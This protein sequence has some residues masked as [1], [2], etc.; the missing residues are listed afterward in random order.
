MVRWFHRWSWRQPWRYNRRNHRKLLV[1]DGTRAYL[2]GFNIH[3]ENS[4]S[5]YGEQRW[6]DTHIGISGPLASE[7][8]ALFGKFWIGRKRQ[9]LPERT[10]SGSMLLSNFT[11]G[12]R[13]YLNGTFAQMLSHARQSIHVTTPY[14]VPNRRTQRLLCEAARRNVD[15]RVLVPRKSDVPL[16]QWAAHAA[17]DLLLDNGVRIF[18]YLPRLLHAK[19]IV[20]DGNYATTG[21]ANMDYR[22]FLLNY[23]LNLFTHDRHLCTELQQQFLQDL[24]EAEEIQAENWKRRFWGGKALEFFGWLARRW[25]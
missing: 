10:G 18:E 17:Y 9:Q 24:S 3:R 6:R 1:V 13:R 16:A 11:V 7:A 4:R 14:F 8:L 19:T 2:G 12:A 22:S 15:V 23:E 5:I 25:L 20:V 21:T